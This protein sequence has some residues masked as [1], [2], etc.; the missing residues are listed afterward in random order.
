V[1]EDL[2]RL[3]GGEVVRPMTMTSA[4]AAPWGIGRTAALCIY[5][6]DM[7]PRRLPPPQHN[8]PG[9]SRTSVPADQLDAAE[10]IYGLAMSGGLEHAYELA[11][12]QFLTASEGLDA[13][14]ASESARVLREFVALAERQAEQ[15]QLDRL[16]ARFAEPDEIMALLEAASASD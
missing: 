16:D 15:E 12:D 9:S 7:P 14:G 4:L 5:N 11:G 6:F 2:V 13:V 3:S 10:H 1:F 8:S